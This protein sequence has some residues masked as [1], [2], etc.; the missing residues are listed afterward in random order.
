MTHQ[1]MSLIERGGEA[2]RDGGE[3]PDPFQ[4]R[5]E[6]E[7]DPKNINVI[8]RGVWLKRF[9][10]GNG[11]LFFDETALRDIN[12]ALAEY[13]GEVLPDCHEERPDKPRGSTAVSKDLQYYPT[14]E[15]VVDRLLCDLSYLD[16]A[17]VLEPSCGCGRILDGLRKRGAKT[18]GIEVDPRS[19]STIAEQRSR[20]HAGKFS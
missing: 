2:L 1:E 10:N 11:H 13:Y 6:R 20:R 18:F 4:S 19:R 17:L 14:P 9:Q 16:G 15:H 12:R 5:Y 3:H 8:A 7:A